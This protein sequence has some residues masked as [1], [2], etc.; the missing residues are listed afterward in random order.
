MS[1]EM[2]YIIVMALVTYLIRALPFVLFRRRIRSRFVRSF[3]YYTPFAVLSAMT[4]PAVFTC[5]GHALSSVVGCAAAV[6]AALMGKKLL[7]VAAAA[8]CAA[9]IAEA[10]LPLLA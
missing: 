10:L 4:V 8:V 2:L 9:F 1:R 6:A 7:F 5:T 3:L